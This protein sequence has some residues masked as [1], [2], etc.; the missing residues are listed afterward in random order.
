MFGGDQSCRHGYVFGI[1]PGFE[2]VLQQPL[3]RE[4]AKLPGGEFFEA[5]V[6]RDQQQPGGRACAG[7][8]HGDPRSQAAADHDNLRMIGV[9]LVEQA[10]GIAGN[11]FLG[12]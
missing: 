2:L 1:A 3:H 11:G 5:V 10:H 12:G 9:D 8:A 7:Q 4:P 6:W